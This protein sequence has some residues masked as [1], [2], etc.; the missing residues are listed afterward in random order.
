MVPAVASAQI[1]CTG[2]LCPYI[3]DNSGGVPPATFFS[4]FA[5]WLVLMVF[6]VIA[7]WKLF[8]KAGQPGWKILIPFYNGVILYR[9]GG[10]SGWLVLLSIIPF[11][12]IVIAVIL[13]IRLA[14]AFAMHEAFSVGLILLPIVF[15]PILAFSKAVY[16]G[17]YYRKEDLLV[18]ATP[19]PPSPSM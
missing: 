10:L 5:V 16:H 15:F 18:A 9:I 13:C 2:N 11:V 4:F 12:N 8:K 6:V 19:M 7:F 14:K 1:T 17:P 3:V